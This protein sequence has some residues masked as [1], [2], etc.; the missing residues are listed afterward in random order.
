MHKR[1]WSVQPTIL[2]S[3]WRAIIIAAVSIATLVFI[4]LLMLT[5][6]WSYLRQPVAHML[7]RELGRTVTIGAITRID[8]GF[9]EPVLRVTDVRI[10]QPDWV[11][12]GDMVAVRQATVR[13]PLLPLLVGH[14]RPEAV[15]IDGVAVALVRFDAQRANWKGLPRGGSGNGLEHVIIRHGTLSLDDRKRDHRFVATVAADDRG[16]RIAGRGTLAGH[17]STLALIGAPL[18]GSAR[19]PFRFVYR[20]AIA[21]GMLTGYADHPLDLGYFQAHAAAYGD[22]LRHLDLL[23]EAGLPGTQPARLSADIRHDRPNWI[24][25][26]LRLRLG[27]SDFAGDLT[28][29]KADGR[30]RV[31][32][33]VRSQALDFDDLASNEGLAR[34][35]AKRR[36][37]GPRIIP[38]TA[39]HLEHLQRTDGT[40]RFDVRHLLFQHRSIFRSAA[41]T[42]SLDHGVLTAAPLTAQLNN[43]TIDGLVRVEHRSGTPRLTL[44]LKLDG[45]RFDALTGGA[46]SGDVTGALLLKGNG[47]TIRAAVAR[48]DGRIGIVAR[49]GAINRR[50]ALFLGADA[51]RALF[52]D[53]SDTTRL[54]CAIGR[55]GVRSGRAVP[56]PLLLD[57]DVSRNEGSGSIDL[58]TER[59]SLVFRGQPKLEHAVQLD[60]PIKVTGTL[61]QPHVV[62]PPVK[63]TVGTALKL[64]GGALGGGDRAPAVGNADCTGLAAKAL[65]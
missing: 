8:H 11:G 53:K 62:P 39:I 44:D 45:A 50:A 14:V 15:E 24:I 34:A 49:N 31:T 47:R 20:S 63:K 33:A 26:S 56:D 3:H 4:L 30:T 65:R 21:G 64:I 51:G 27:R 23:V 19:W 9:S 37:Y 55:F 41:G 12:G 43:G 2:H 54:R 35:A 58:A 13:L 18:T 7:S 32:G 59:L 6:G 48:S 16:L 22:D 46:A 29:Q 25:R 61:S 38:D 57:T 60:L 28:V 52:A 42:L 5:F 10:A 17:P 1:L 40:I 36:L